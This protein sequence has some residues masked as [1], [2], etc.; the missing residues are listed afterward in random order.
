MREWIGECCNQDEDEGP[1][2]DP[3]TDFLSFFYSS[4]PPFLDV[5][6][7]PYD[8]TDAYYEFIS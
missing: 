4:R 2:A 8:L 6:N 7:G 3:P 1:T 5:R